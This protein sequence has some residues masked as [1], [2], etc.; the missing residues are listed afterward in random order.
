MNSKLFLP[1]AV[2]VGIVL[3]AGCTQTGGTGTGGTSGAIIGNKYTNQEHGFSL[4][5]PSGWTAQEGGGANALSV[6]VLCIGPAK[7]GIATNMNLVAESVG[8]TSLSAYMA[9][10]KQTL[11]VIGVTN[12]TDEG[13]TTVNNIPAYFIEF[14]QAATGTQVKQKQV[15]FVKSGYAYVLTFTAAPSAYAQQ[16]SAL[17]T[18]LS[19]FKFTN[20]TNTG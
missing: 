10:A 8:Q 19:T 17:D 7:G 18:T 16:V 12:F 13:V 11:G 3:V 9:S 15:I 14:E 20:G 6:L 5:C 4:D 2:L 1:L